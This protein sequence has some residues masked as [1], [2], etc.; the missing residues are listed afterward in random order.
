MIKRIK[1]HQSQTGFTLVEMAVVLA[2]VALLLGGLLPTISSQI[3]QQRRND[4]RKQLDE[5]QSALVGYAI[6]HG[7][8]PCPAKSASDGTEDRNAATGIC[9]K[10]I[11]FLPWAELGT[12][13]LDSWG[14]IFLY[15]ASFNFTNAAPATLFTLTSTRDITVKTRDTTGALINLSKSGDIPAVV[16][17][18]GSNGIFGTLDNGNA[19]PNTAPAGTNNIDDQNQNTAGTVGG[20]LSGTAFMSRDPAAPVNSTDAAFD[21]LVVWLSPNALMNRMV[22]AGKLP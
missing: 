22:A 16:L 18:T 9:I 12:S 21:D 20:A 4:T 14:R 13:K 3:E 5:I 11:G 7:Y 10:R 8:L 19:V 6:S 1:N 17:S 15:S 2:I